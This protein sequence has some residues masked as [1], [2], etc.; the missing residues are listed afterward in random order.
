MNYISFDMG[1]ESMAAFCHLEAKTESTPVDLQEYA[2]ALL[3]EDVKEETIDYLCKDNGDKSP[4]L[5]TRISIN[6]LR[7]PE[8]LPD[9]H[10]K[11]NFIDANGNVIKQNNN[12]VCD[13]SLFGFFYLKGQ[14]LARKVLPNPKIPFQEGAR[15]II[16]EVETK[17]EKRCR[18]EPET[19][20]R[21]LMVQILSNFV[22]KSSQ[23]RGINLQDD[24]TY[25]ILTIPNV[26]SLSHAQSIKKFVKERLNVKNVETIYE[27]DAI[28]YY[29]RDVRQ[30]HPQVK[31]FFKKMR[32]EKKSGKTEYQILTFDIGHGTTDLS[33]M[34]ITEPDRERTDASDPSQTSQINPDNRRRFFVRARTGKSEGGSKLNYILAKYYNSCLER[35]MEREEFQDFKMDFDFLTGEL[36]PTQALIVKNLE[37]LINEV[38]KSMTENYEI[39]LAKE[40]QEE[41][42]DAMI[43]EWLEKIP[44]DKKNEEKC[45]KFKKAF[46]DAFLLIK[47]PGP[48]KSFLAEFSRFPLL[49]R[50]VEFGKLRKEI[51]DYVEGN[52]TEILK[53]LVEMAKARENVDSAKKNRDIIDKEQT[54][55]VIAGQASQFKPIQK[56]IRKE[57]DRLN[58]PQNYRLFLEGDEAKEAC[59]RGAIIYKRSAN[60]WANST[61]IHGCYG[62]LNELEDISDVFEGLDTKELNSGRKVNITF[63][64]DSTYWLIYSPRAFHTIKKDNPPEFSDGTTALLYCFEN[65][66]VFDVEYDTNT[67]SLKV[68]NIPDLKLGTY[69]GALQSIYPKVWPVVLKKGKNITD[70]PYKRKKYYRKPGRI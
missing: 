20:I 21:H 62:F 49:R 4:R 2:Q 30:D 63:N 31:E 8:K 33:L 56:S 26:Y 15:D 3:G 13:Q 60:L 50:T 67:F 38:K 19:L 12:K 11:M 66:R 40:K 36:E 41:Y 32:K 24:N 61:E 53:Q 6:D 29:V 52:V 37:S 70:D 47:L 51:E 23:L 16:P 35:L 25:L 48:I 14:E 45:E 7:Q 17:D 58:I 68:N 5:R 69:G 65:S 34:E 43:K 57:L 22:F 39:K 59:S 1:S 27:S 28:S 44:A 54:L 46:K 9:D 55:V 42:I 64:S 10:A 18:Y